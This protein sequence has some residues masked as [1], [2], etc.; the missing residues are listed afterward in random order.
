MKIL[1]RLPNWLGD[2]VMSTGFLVE[3]RRT[4]PEAAIDVILKKE[5]SGLAAFLP[6]IS[7]VYPFSKA[8]YPG[9]RGLLRFGRQL[10]ANKYDLFFSLP[11]SLSA[12]VMGL[13]TGAK[14]RVGYRKEGRSL[15]LTHAYAKPV[16]HH[17]A[18]EYVYLL[19]Q[20]LG[21]PLE[22]VPV[23]L[24]VKPTAKAAAQQPTVILNFN[25]EAQSRRM[26]LPK[27]VAMYQALHQQLK[28]QFVLIGGPKDA[29]FSERI[30]AQA[31]NPPNLA[32]IAGK[33][34][35]TALVEALAAADLVVTTDSGP[36]HV[37]N[38]LNK[39]MIVF[40]GAGDEANTGPYNREVAFVMRVPNLVCAPCRSNT[41]RFGEPVCLAQ[42]SEAQLV[43]HAVALL[44]AKS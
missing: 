30:M 44:A 26:P 24:E 36:A 37:A 19:E 27:A 40:F 29:T 9:L 32:S 4:F 20:Y 1:V 2:M 35:L 31:G 17:R 3:L 22:K 14:V 8:E 43:R 41:C 18:D 11:D 5:Y 7:A 39:K 15:L 34:S 33:T 42:Q 25:S 21:Y 38:S 6:A 12:A 28:A 23:R 16:A 10:A 13:A